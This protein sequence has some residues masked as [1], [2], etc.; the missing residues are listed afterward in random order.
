[1]NDPLNIRSLVNSRQGTVKPAIYTDQA[2]YDLEL[3]RIFARSWLF[4]THES[5]IPKAGD[6]FTT[7]MGEDPV[8]VVREKDGSIAAFLNQCRHRGMKL[9]HAD[10]GNTKMFTCAYHGWAF[11]LDG[12]LSSV[13]LE[14]QAYRNKLDKSKWGLIKVPRL[15]VYKGLV[16][17]NWDRNAPSL[18]D[19]LG[20]M[21]WYLDGFLD[22][23]EGGVE[24]VG[25]IH[26]WVI[27]CNWKFAAEQ[28]CSDQYHAPYT[29]ASAVQVLQVA[30]ENKAD[31][32]P[33]G[34]GQTARPVW[35]NAQGGVQFSGQGHG[36]AFF[37]TEKADANVWVAGAVSNYFRDTYA[38]AEQRLGRVRALRLAGH[39][40]MFPSL[41]WLNGTQT[42]RIWHPK[43]PNQIEVWAFCIADKQAPDEV[44]EALKLSHARAFGPAGFLEQD[45]SEN[46]VEVQKVLK[47]RI[48]QQ[49]DFCIQMGIGFEERRQDGIPGVTN[50][51]FAETAA[52]GFYQRWADMMT[53]ESWDEIEALSASYE[54]EVV[55]G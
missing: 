17:G 36:S 6:F 35:A 10:S 21:A 24:V 41:S 47:G 13:P 55:N 18:E 25:G 7:F 37:F 31:G 46:W 27:D 32:A 2:I 16:F 29:H 9:C 28:F 44:K 43:G 42:L 34:D 14:E 48:A 26:K 51:T 22:R 53:A 1:M 20:D 33:L 5:L 12:G 8:V 38:E 30:T 52:R 11:G 23:R 19:Y 40:T 50:Y 54:K 49:S 45:D 3:E 39:N 15:S 4:L